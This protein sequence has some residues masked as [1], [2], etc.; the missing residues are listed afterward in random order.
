MS[1]EDEVVDVAVIGGGLSGL[2]CAEDLIIKHKIT[3][4][5]VIEK[6][7]R[8]GGRNLS[9]PLGGEGGAVFDLGGQWV[10]PHQKT[11]LSLAERLG[12]R[13]HRQYNTGTKVMDYAGKVATYEADI[14][15][16]S[17][18][19]LIDIHFLMS[20]VQGLIDQI[21]A[22]DPM[23]APNAIALDAQSCESYINSLAWTDGAKTLFKTAIQAV[24]G[25]EPSEVSALFVLWYARQSDSFKNLIEI[26][27]GNQQYT[28]VGGAQQLSLKLVERIGS[29]RVKLGQAVT[30]IDYSSSPICLRTSSGQVFRARKVVCAF[31]P[32]WGAAIHFTPALPM[33]R[34]QLHQRAFM[35]SIAKV[36]LLYDQPYWRMKK[37]S[38]EVICDCSLAD[39]PTFNVFDDTLPTTGKEGGYQPA[40]VCFINA[41]ANRNWCDRSEED[42]VKGCINQCVRWFGP[43]LGKPTHTAVMNWT[44]EKSMMG[45]PIGLLPPGLLTSTGDALRRPVAGKLFWAGT[46]AAVY[47]QGFMDGAV[48]AGLAASAQVVAQLHSS[49]L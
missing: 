44:K 46:E 21:P 26:T 37:Y 20:R 16:M 7:D 41:Q 17:V 32:S 39:S 19:S 3:N 40:L 24:F 47:G 45:G 1:S 42:L 33:P 10:G 18:P 4:V 38:G 12:V 36:I 15:S 30:E 48:I 5:I 9:T 13:L 22:T 43:E 35:G 11:L 25:C 28:F 6:C 23:K 34:Q 31:P 2:S 14:P 29:H 8:V 49:K 27:D